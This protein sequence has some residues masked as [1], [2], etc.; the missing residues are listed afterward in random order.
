MTNV[1]RVI[2]L[3]V[4][5]HEQS[6]ET[7]SIN[8]MEITTSG[9]MKHHSLASSNKLR[10]LAPLIKFTSIS[11]TVSDPS[12]TK[13][14]RRAD[15]FD[16]TGFQKNRLAVSFARHCNKVDRFQNAEPEYTLYTR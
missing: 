2:L 9:D 7:T 4:T 6:V 12:E 8:M 5:W 14:I 3:S 11:H 10:G 16:G 15:K 1:K 13:S